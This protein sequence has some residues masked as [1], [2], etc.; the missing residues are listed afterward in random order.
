MGRR[1][2][3]VFFALGGFSQIAQALLIRELLVS[4]QGNEISI[5]FFYGSWLWWIALGGLAAARLD[6]HRPVLN[7]AFLV[8]VILPALPLLLASQMALTRMAR[9][10]M[11][12]PSSEFIPLGHLA[13]TTF[14]I[15]LP[16]GIAIGFLFP[17]ACKI[18]AER[19]EAPIT[20]LYILESLGALAG[21]LL[22]TFVLVEWLGGWRIL[23][24]MTALFGF[25]GLLL[26]NPG[27]P[28]PAPSPAP[29]PLVDPSP[30]SPSPLPFKATSSRWRWLSVGVGCLGLLLSWPPLGSVLEERMEAWRFAVNHPGLSLVGARETRYGHVALARFGD[31][32]SVVTDGRVG[33][34][35]PDRR[36]V[37]GDAA[38]FFSQ[39]GA[40]KRILILDGWL[41]GLGAELLRYPVTGLDVVSQDRLA[42]EQIRPH[43]PPETLGALS[44]P[45]MQLHFMDGRSFAN[46]LTGEERYDL[47][48]VLVGDPASTRQNRY[49]TR[50]FYRG[51]KKGM[52]ETGVL[53]T[54]VGSASNYLGREVQ[55]YSGS[56]FRTLGRVFPHPVVAPGDQHTFCAS[57]KPGVVSQNPDL[58][59]ERHEEID[60]PEP[61]PPKDLFHLMLPPRR[62]AFVHQRLEQEKGEI[63]TDQRPV[64]FFLN[65]VLTG[66][67]TASGIGEVLHR[68]KGMGFWPWLVPPL[69]WVGL[70]LVRGWLA[71]EGGR[72]GGGVAG[73]RGGGKTDGPVDGRRGN[74]FK[75]GALLALA[76]LGF[77]AMA[78]QLMVLF[79]YQA[80]VG[81]VFGRIALLNGLF[82]V[83]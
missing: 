42:F 19:R 67:L 31:Q 36:R 6:R 46:A 52:S 80:G 63:N 56:V 44:D 14:L 21:A 81:F 22:F 72:G 25:V 58:L 66:K 39:G 38:Y 26:F 13:A 23:W 70:L 34:S 12:L 10:F 11:A 50:D 53:C 75:S 29:S 74:L 83:G 24:L 78:A 54:R 60:L 37:A 45:R 76:A 15:T 16:T 35:F 33:E 20:T 82:M 64:T 18:L 77:I 40:P 71:D 48:L 7:P 28:S 4:F 43:L 55:S 27:S 17:L 73:N 59:Q 5:G 51:L 79:G 61:H 9:F 69:V 8:G 2:H 3:F 68:L 32:H 47:V 49:F 41:G 62:V 57:G 1:L 65:L 30:G